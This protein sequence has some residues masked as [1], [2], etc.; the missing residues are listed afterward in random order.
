MVAGPV[1]SLLGTNP[2][3]RLALLALAISIFVAGCSRQEI[4]VDLTQEALKQLRSGEYDEAIKTSSQ[5]IGQKPDSAAAYLY[6]GR[7]YHYRNAMGDHQRAIGDFSE[8][9][10]LAPESSDAYYSRALARRDLG[11]AELA[12]ADETKARELDEVVQDTYRRMPDLTP[13]ADVSESAKLPAASELSGSE[14][15]QKK[16]YEKLKGRFEPGFGELRTPSSRPADGSA[17]KSGASLNDRYRDLLE[18]ANRAEAEKA[19]E[20]GSPLAGQSPMPTPGTGTTSPSAVPGAAEP[21][22]A[23]N[24]P[25]G[26]G[27]ARALEAWQ[28]PL[29]PPPLTSPFAQRTA[30]SP[31]GQMGPNVNRNLQ[32]PFQQI[33]PG[34]TGFTPPQNPFGA[35]SRQPN[36]SPVTRP[37]GG[38]TT[39]RFSNPNVRPANP[40]D[41]VP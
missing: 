21:G 28:G 37:F 22:S 24:P 30:V 19:A 1:I 41:F 5:A 18:Q 29:Q 25:R 31:S 34:G 8:A 38:S 16:V 7:A 6:R 4:P 2:M 40:R 20:A 26:R 39:S 36:A 15:E 27:N 17:V 23:T 14:E 11:Q 35:Q 33:A 3:A 9:I 10:R 32:S 13:P 12:A